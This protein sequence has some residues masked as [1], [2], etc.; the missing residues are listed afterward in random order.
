MSEIE[1]SNLTADQPLVPAVSSHPRSPR[2]IMGILLITSNALA[3]VLIAKTFHESNRGD[4]VPPTL[5]D[6]VDST[7]SQTANY[8]F[9]F[10]P[11]IIIASPNVASAKEELALLRADA[12][13]CPTPVRTAPALRLHQ[14]RAPQVGIVAASTDA[15]RIATW[16]E[17]T[18][19][20]S[21]DGGARFSAV[22]T[23]R[24]NDAAFVDAA[25]D[26]HGRL[27]VL[28]SDNAVAM[29][30]GPTPMV[31]HPTKLFEPPNENN[32][33]PAKLVGG[34]PF[35]MMI[36]TEIDSE[37]WSMFAQSK[38]GGISWQTATLT[39][40]G[41]HQIHTDVQPNGNVLIAAPRFDCDVDAVEVFSIL[42]GVAV[43]SS[44]N[45]WLNSG[46][47]VG[48]SQ[49]RVFS[50]QCEGDGCSDSLAFWRPPFDRDV[51]RFN[52]DAPLP[53][54]GWI[55]STRPLPPTIQTLNNGALHMI[56]MAQDP[57][58]ENGN[59]PT[60]P[61]TFVALTTSAPQK[62]SQILPCGTAMTIDANAR[63]WGINDGQLVRS[64]TRSAPCPVHITHHS[65]RPSQR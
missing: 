1:P 41:S 36:G 35:T 24:G 21:T 54:A 47:L 26:C 16:D 14:F 28:R 19:W 22:F 31:F 37:D 3:V 32:K 55:D 38:D 33:A 57:H 6:T 34:G 23:G 12:G 56:E 59:D 61:T 13:P 48:V 10:A 46:K 50:R 20:L 17:S 49:G 60:L 51:E 39:T 45:P 2:L 30:G 27:I 53:H 4:C 58:G 40:S 62:A 18:V 63:V 7:A 65:K 42:Q 64:S 5:P 15:R 52:P 43:E 29:A 11:E 9:V 8:S 25:F 44:E